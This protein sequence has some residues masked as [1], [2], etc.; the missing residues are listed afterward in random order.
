[1]GADVHQMGAGWSQMEPDGSRCRPD[2]ARWGPDGTRFIDFH[3]ISL[4]FMSFHS[5]SWDL[6][7]PMIPWV[8]KPGGGSGGS[9]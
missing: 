4:F 7:S 1:M 9:G 3:R 2:G 8:L 6:G 5:F